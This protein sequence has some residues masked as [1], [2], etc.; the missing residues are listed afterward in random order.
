[1]N[2]GEIV[3]RFRPCIVGGGGGGSHLKRLD[4]CALASRSTSSRSLRANASDTAARFGGLL[5]SPW[6]PC[7]CPC[8]SASASAFSATA[9]AVFRAGTSANNGD[10][11]G[12]VELQG[13]LALLNAALSRTPGSKAASSSSEMAGLPIL[14]R[15][16]ALQAGA[17]QPKKRRKRQPG[18]G[19]QKTAAPACCA[20]TLPKAL[21]ASRA[22]MSYARR[23]FR[24]DR[25]PGARADSGG[26]AQASW[27]SWGQVRQ[28]AGG[29]VSRGSCQ[30]RY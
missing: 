24:R 9:G 18:G 5:L 4:R 21:C 30:A 27:R 22:A 2:G 10:C 8:A 16:L 12:F 28:D 1:M 17:D 11:R 15:E 7:P 29:K 6:R 20:P 3:G 13:L 19:A 26:I 25:A 14:R 23:N